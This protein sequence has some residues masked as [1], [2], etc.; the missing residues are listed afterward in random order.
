MLRKGRRAEGSGSSHA[1]KPYS[2][3]QHTKKLQ[4]EI[5]NDLSSSTRGRRLQ[6]LGSS[7][8][9][10]KFFKL[11]DPF[12]CRHASALVQLRTGHALLNHHLARIGK[13]P[14]PSCPN[15]GASYETVHFV[16]TCPVCHEERRRMQMKIGARRMRLEHLLTSASPLGTFYSSLPAPIASPRPLATPPP[17]NE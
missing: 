12:P 10:G 14:S 1:I 15:C 5:V 16:L 4:K 7:T 9:S 2:I 13:V 3:Q 8:T 6:S 11:T 17:N